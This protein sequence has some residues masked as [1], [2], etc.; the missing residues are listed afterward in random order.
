VPVETTWYVEKRIFYQRFYGIIGLDD[1]RLSLEQTGQ[2]MAEGTPLIHAIADLRQIEKYPPMF[3]LTRMARRTG[4]PGIGWTVIV[5]TNPVMR[6]IGSILTQFT[7][8]HYHVASTLEDALD[9]LSSRDSTLE[10]P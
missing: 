3:D 8:S 4:F 10:L 9:F 1:F 6:F 5:V 7:V 2:F